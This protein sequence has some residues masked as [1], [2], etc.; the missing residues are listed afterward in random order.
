MYMCMHGTCICMYYILKSEILASPTWCIVSSTCSICHS[1][2]GY[3]L[4][5][6]FLPSTGVYVVTYVHC[7]LTNTANYGG[8]STT[9]M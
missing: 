9:C 1:C 5:I 2:P 8:E 4:T 3:K 7:I 6:T